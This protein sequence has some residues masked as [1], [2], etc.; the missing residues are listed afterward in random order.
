MSKIEFSEY[1]AGSVLWL[2][3]DALRYGDG[4][5]RPLTERDKRALEEAR[6]SIIRSMPWL[7][8]KGL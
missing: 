8:K 6:G 4:M 5:A 3:D 2:I 1:E 7:D